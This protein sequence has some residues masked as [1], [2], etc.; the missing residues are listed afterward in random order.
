MPIN[1]RNETAYLCYVCPNC[2]HA[3]HE[4]ICSS[5]DDK[6][7][8]LPYHLI[9]IDVNIQKHLQV[10]YKKG[11]VTEFS[12]ESHS[13]DDRVQ[14]GFAIDYGFGDD[15]PMPHGFKKSFMKDHMNNK[16]IRCF[17]EARYGKTKRDRDNLS[18]EDFEKM[19]NEYL[20][21]LLDWCESLPMAK[22][23]DWEQY[24]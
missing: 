24:I 12:C 23:V 17:I 4:C 5:P 8:I 21:N 6:Y 19:K 1:P 15:L 11:Y 7:D 3:P 13:P 10:L 18:S 22:E 9:A 16:R 2:L 20:K 14:I